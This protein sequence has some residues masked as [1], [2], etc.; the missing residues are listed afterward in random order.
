MEPLLIGGGRVEGDARLW[1]LT[2]PPAPAYADAQLDDYRRLPRARFP[3]RPP[4]RL[5]LLARASSPAPTG[6]LGFGFWNDPFTLSLGQ[7]GA[8]RRWPAAPN[9]VWFFY[10]SPPNQMELAPGV[11]GHGWKAATLNAGRLPA[12][13]LAPAALATVGLSALPGVRKMVMAAG[14]KMVRASERLLGADLSQWGEYE[15]VWER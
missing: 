12:A 2:L 5:R 7:G 15:I 3:W 8:A 4:L 11:P 1:R 14:R 10:A 6:T 9:T 13:L